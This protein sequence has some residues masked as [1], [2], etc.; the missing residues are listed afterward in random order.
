MAQLAAIFVAVGVAFGLL[1]GD[2]V[3]VGGIAGTLLFGLMIGVGAL[4]EAIGRGKR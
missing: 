1:R 4:V 2:G 3:L